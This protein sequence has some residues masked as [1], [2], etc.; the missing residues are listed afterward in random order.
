MVSRHF[1]FATR[2]KPPLDRSRTTIHRVFHHQE[3]DAKIY[4]AITGKSRG[5][6]TLRLTEGLGHQVHHFEV[7]SQS[8]SQNNHADAR[9]WVEPGGRFVASYGTVVAA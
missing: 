3:D 9:I 4:N 7:A 5:S 6:I 8:A 2:L 1:S